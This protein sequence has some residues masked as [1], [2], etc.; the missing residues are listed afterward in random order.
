MF[1]SIAIIGRPNVGK[2]TLFNKLTKSRDAIVSDFP[3]LTKDRNYGFLKL[4]DKRALLVDTGG[5]AKDSDEIKEAISNQAW[6]AVE[7]SEVV[8]FL[9]D[10]SE[11]L[12]N[13]DLEII[14]KLRKLN[15]QYI[16]ILNKIDKKSDGL[17]KEDLKKKGVENYLEI[18]AEHSKNLNKIKQEL[19]K[20]STKADIEFPEGKK[21]AILGRPNA[22]KSTFIN[23]LI[24]EDRLIVSEIAGTTIDAI[25]VPFIFNNEE[26]ILID[27]A[28][29]RKGYKRN[30]KVEYFSF[31]RA[32]HA[33]DKSDIVIFICDID[34]GVVDQ[35]MKILNMIIDNGKPVLF[36]LNKVDLVSKKELKTKYLTKK[37]QSEFLR[38]I[39]QVEISAL[40]KKGF[41]RVFEL[42]NNII[43]KSQRNFTTSMLNKL[44]EK[45]ITTNPPPSI[46]GRQIKFK[47]VHFGGIHP[48]TFII[49]SN[50][51]KKI[52]KNYRK[53]L[54]NS[55]RT[56][57][58]LKSIQ[59]KIIFRKS[60]NPY[61]GKK[62][63][64][65]ERQIKKRKRLVKH[66]KKS[67]K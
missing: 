11:S 52:P 1:T 6:I 2:S 51:D 16:T 3:G 47:H 22:G 63:K 19:E 10:G 48:T 64:L 24:N 37:M 35:D 34:D 36:A 40:N 60:D 28:G 43:R 42:A 59:L 21:V 45:F 32:M 53:Y 26:F 15:K 44:L 33:I 54:E 30:H 13:L 17:I 5:I 31:V 18:S 55:F 39:E 38:N 67:K 27:T 14:S 4:K 29:I 12:S 7:E 8:L 49:H 9:L 58:D 62:N 20:R 65:S 41:N 23:K 56:E 66:I 25:S 50:Q 46:S 61:E 57:L